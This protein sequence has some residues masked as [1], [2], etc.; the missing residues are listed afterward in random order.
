MDTTS[1]LLSTVRVG[2]IPIEESP[3]R[4]LIEDLWG[5]SCVGLV[6]GSPKVG[7]S[8]LGLDMA[9]S[10]ATGTACLGTFPVEDPGPVLVYLAEDALPVVR[11]RVAGL[12]RHRGLDLAR[13]D[14]H[15]ITEPTLRL[16]RSADRLRL[17]ATAAQLRP[18]M[19]LL[20]PL[21]R[22]HSANENDATEIAEL[23][24]YFRQLQRRLDTSVILVHHTRKNSTG[25]PHAGQSLR[26]SSDFWA[27]SDCNLY[28]RR[29]KDHVIL[30]MEHRAARAPKPVYVEL[31]T[32]NEGTI[33]L[34]VLGTAMPESAPEPDLRE[35]V[36]NALNDAPLTRGQLRERLA[37]KNERL[38]RALA[39]L[40]S[41]GELERTAQ[42]WRRDPRQSV[43]PRSHPG[44]EGNGNDR[45]SPR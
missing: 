20:D 4:W 1:P 40:E 11:E 43:V 21:V 44:D 24:S 10:V 16:D 17:L 41:R 9:V 34:E 15:V 32:A 30:S 19:V 6:G 5:A 29:A 27:W 13:L 35:L 14:L 7:K 3:R 31:A 22:L 18:R 26:G 12:V 23:L 2:E 42:G 28:L 39:E 8:W 33:H 38:G 36:L 45:L 25:G 37:V